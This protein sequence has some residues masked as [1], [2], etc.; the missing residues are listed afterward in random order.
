V[1]KDDL[2][3]IKQLG[4]GDVAFGKKRR[5]RSRR[6]TSPRCPRTRRPASCPAGPGCTRTAIAADGCGRTG[7]PDRL[8]SLAAGRAARRGAP[9]APG[10]TSRGRGPCTAAS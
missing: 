7:G 5:P 6:H 8:P 2:R 4:V 10:S 1:S 9:A 3:E